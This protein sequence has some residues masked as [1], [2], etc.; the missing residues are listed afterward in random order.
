MRFRQLLAEIERDS[1]W[2]TPSDAQLDAVALRLGAADIGDIVDA[3]D[4]LSRQKERLP[5]WDGDGQDGIASAQSL[6]TSLLQRMAARHREAIEA[7]LAGSEPLT[8][9][10]LEIALGGT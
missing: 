6:L 9:G 5:L 3:L 10:Y 4:E 2:A 8:R 1:P 7:R